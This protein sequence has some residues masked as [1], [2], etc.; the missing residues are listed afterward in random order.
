MGTGVKLK[1]LRH[2]PGRGRRPCWVNKKTE[3]K[4]QLGTAENLTRL[5]KGT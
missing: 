4:K 2:S 1:K 3:S 5:L